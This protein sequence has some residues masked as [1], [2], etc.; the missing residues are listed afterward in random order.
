MLHELPPAN[1]TGTC[2]VCTGGDA[3]RSAVTCRVRK[4]GFLTPAG[5]AMIEFEVLGEIGK[6]NC[7]AACVATGT[8]NH[9]LLLDCGGNCLHKLPRPYLY[10]MQAV[11]FRIFT[12]ITTLDLMNCSEPC[13]VALALSCRLSD[14]RALVASFSTACWGICGITLSG[15]PVAFVFLNSTGSSC[16]QFGC[17]RQSDLRSLTKN[18]LWQHQ[19][20]S[21]STKISAWMPCCWTMER[22][23]LAIAFRSRRNSPLT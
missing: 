4:L 8:A 21:C 22:N 12:S 14:L 18:P 17:S 16:G 10:G 15:F 5:L 19:V 7:V 1:Q 13:G 23:V 20:L 2:G 9:R 6:D 11:F 3:G